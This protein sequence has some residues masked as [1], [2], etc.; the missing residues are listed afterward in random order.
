MFC[1]NS[2]NFDISFNWFP[3]AMKHIG[4]HTSV[5]IVDSWTLSVPNIC[6][7]A[8]WNSFL[9]L[10]TFMTI[11]CFDAGICTELCVQ[12]YSDLS[13]CSVSPLEETYM[14]THLISAQR[15]KHQTS[16]WEIHNHIKCV[17]CVSS[18]IAG[19]QCFDHVSHMV[20]MSL[21]TSTQ[22]FFWAS[23]LEVNFGFIA[24]QVSSLHLV[25][26]LPKLE[27]LLEILCSEC[28]PYLV[29]TF[30]RQLCEHERD[31]NSRQPPK[32]V[33]LST[34]VIINK[35]S[36]FWLWFYCLTESIA[37][38]LYS[39]TYNCAT[40]K[41]CGNKNIAVWQTSVLRIATCHCKRA[42]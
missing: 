19:W 5:K 20:L 17:F 2:P 28:C 18:W 7:K 14:C 35:G 12:R 31:T 10:S 13:L 42:S 37:S 36:P 33:L 34:C 38:I 22:R 39:Q 4:V 15:H 30:Q 41:P 16:L 21:K 29:E 26:T 23:I 40:Q 9:G 8:F 3:Q 24:N 25:P 6:Q 11:L 27:T 1:S 32:E